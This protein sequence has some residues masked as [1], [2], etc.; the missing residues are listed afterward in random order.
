MFRFGTCLVFKERVLD[1]SIEGSA[2][3]LE[4]RMGTGAKTKISK[5]K[6]IELYMF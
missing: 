3:V 5:W 4:K 6:Q 2:Q 1:F